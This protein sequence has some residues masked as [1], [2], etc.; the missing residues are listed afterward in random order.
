MAPGVQLVDHENGTASL[1]GTPTTPGT[2]QFTIGA[3]TGFLTYESDTTQLFT[4]IVNPCRDSDSVHNHQP[5]HG[6]LGSHWGAFRS[7][8]VHRDEHRVAHA[9][10]V[11]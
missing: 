5:R 11:R 3:N 7:G 6:Y 8:P 4:L 1:R 10:A 2:Y 9:G